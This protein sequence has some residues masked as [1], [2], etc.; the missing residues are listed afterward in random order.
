M[1]NHQEVAWTLG[2]IES[3]PKL[4]TNRNYE[5]NSSGIGQWCTVGL[6]K[7]FRNPPF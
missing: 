5:W 7:S 6:S 2:R 3:Q 4:L 1:V